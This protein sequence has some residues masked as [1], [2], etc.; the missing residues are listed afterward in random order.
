MCVLTG[1]GLK[2]PG[3]AIERA[4]GVV[5]CEPTIDAVEDAVLGS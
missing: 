3:T 5:P 2:D 4:T 1:P